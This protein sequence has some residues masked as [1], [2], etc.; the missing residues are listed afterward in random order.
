MF[1]VQKIII[2]ATNNID[3]MQSNRQTWPLDEAVR[4]STTLGL[5]FSVTANKALLP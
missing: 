1:Q 2:T 4:K 3:D 5:I